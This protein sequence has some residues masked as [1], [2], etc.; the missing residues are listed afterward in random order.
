MFLQGVQEIKQCIDAIYNVVSQ[1]DTEIFPLHAN[2]SS[3]EQRAVFLPTSKWKIVVAT[4]VAEVCQPDR[5][6]SHP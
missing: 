2:L 4:N 1:V 5:G 3:N 6:A